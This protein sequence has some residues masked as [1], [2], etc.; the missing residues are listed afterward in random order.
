M[1]LSIKT[2]IR[3]A[4]SAVLFFTVLFI[5][6]DIV[7][8]INKMIRLNKEIAA[9][10]EDV[11]I[12]T[13]NEREK[14]KKKLEEKLL[15]AQESFQL[16]KSAVSEVEDQIVKGKNIPLVTL[17]IEKLVSSS[18]VELV[19]VKPNEVQRK[20]TINILPIEIRIKGEYAQ[21]IDFLF[22]LEAS[23]SFISTGELSITHNP[24]IYPQLE[25]R[26]TP[27]I[28]FASKVQMND[29]REE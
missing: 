12:L 19:F 16:I 13:D 22:R 23:S 11:R 9:S 5:F 1:N 24:L 18:R 4:L 20:G 15:F 29:V 21:L 3:Y 28:A 8:Q 27:W 10:K 14:L 26:L 25:I 2:I 17:E 6:A 7:P